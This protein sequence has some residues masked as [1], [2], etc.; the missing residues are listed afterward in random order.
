MLEANKLYRVKRG[1]EEKEVGFILK[2]VVSVDV[3]GSGSRP[4][5]LADLVNLTDG[6]LL[7]APGAYAFLMLPEYIYLNGS[8]DSIDPVNFSYELLPDVLS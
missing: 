5:A 6:T 4:T 8:A 2:G 7:T 3:L 1:Q